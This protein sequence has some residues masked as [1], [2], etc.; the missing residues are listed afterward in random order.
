M[1]PRYLLQEGEPDNHEN[2]FTLIG[3]FSRSCMVHNWFA[4][5]NRMKLDMRGCHLLIYDNTDL[6]SLGELLTM[7]LQPY[8]GAF[9]SVRLWKSYRRIGGDP[10][11][12]G[13]TGWKKSKLPHIYAMQLDLM[14][15]VHTDK[16]VL[17]E[18]D[19]LAPPDAV[20]QLLS[21]LEKN[22]K[23]G[24]AIAIETGRSHISYAK[25]RLGVHYLHREKNRIIWRLSPSP[26]LRGVHKV[27][28]CGWYCVAS[29]KWLW[30]RGFEGMDEY[31]QD[32]PRFAMDVIH[33][34]NIHELGYDILADFSLWC[35]H[36]QSTEHGF[37]F[38]G[39]K[40]AVPQ[41][42]VWLPAWQEYAQGVVLTKPCHKKMLRNLTRQR[43]RN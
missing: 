40:Q 19:T 24:V 39:K 21:L 42:D 17:I 38:W 4:H 10:V 8:I 14:R 3:T 18:D 43:S 5:L 12:F 31:V 37:I 9:R 41:L 15:H 28:A 13:D 30:L 32:V 6:A 23:C 27:D 25:V 33:T 26:H 20:M 2:S 1:T 35:S 34:H 16:F 36:V 29:Y 11:T 7:K 22:E